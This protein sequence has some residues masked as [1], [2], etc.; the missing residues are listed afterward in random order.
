MHQSERESNE[1]SPPSHRRIQR[2]HP[3]NYRQPHIRTQNCASGRP[4]TYLP[5]YLPYASRMS[6]AILPHSSPMDSPSIQHKSIFHPLSVGWG[7]RTPSKSM[8]NLTKNVENYSERNPSRHHSDS[9]EV[10]DRHRDYSHF[11]QGRSIPHARQQSE[12]SHSIDASVRNNWFE[13]C[14]HSVA[15]CAGARSL[16]YSV[17]HS[18]CSI[19]FVSSIHR[20]AM[21]DQLLQP[22]TIH[23][24]SRRID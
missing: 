3:P 6:A 5:M 2:N 9:R 15:C 13:H 8:Q 1:F 23:T 22:S 18:V 21:P 24:H 20:S 11:D 10:A 19:V 17:C 14:P 16:R 4:C 7:S 12:W